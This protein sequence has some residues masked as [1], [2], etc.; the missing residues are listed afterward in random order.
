MCNL[1]AISWRDQIIFW[2]DDDDEVLF[3]LDQHTEQDFYSVSS[4]KQQSAQF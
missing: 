4:L 2:W 1:S 3:V